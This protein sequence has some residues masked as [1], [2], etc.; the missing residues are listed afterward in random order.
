LPS[1]RAEFTPELPSAKPQD[2]F[3]RQHLFLS[4]ASLAAQS[5]NAPPK[6]T[7]SYTSLPSLSNAL[8]KN[9]DSNAD[10]SST[11]LGREEI[12]CDDKIAFGPITPARPPSATSEFVT[13]TTMV[14][15]RLPFVKEVSVG[16][17]KRSDIFMLVFSVAEPV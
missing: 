15:N 10:S 5:L 3:S 7:Q 4:R 12:Y 13:T 1:S 6:T 14:P 16:G 11:D 8:N 2:R 17:A 9:L